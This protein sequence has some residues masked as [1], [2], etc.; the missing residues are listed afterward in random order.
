MIKVFNVQYLRN[1]SPYRVL[2][3]AAW[4][5][6]EAVRLCATGI[7]RPIDEDPELLAAIKVYRAPRV[8]TPWEY[9]LCQP[10]FF[11]FNR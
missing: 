9:Y 10:N 8:N 3:V 7:C 5:L 2:E 1:A 6:D 11:K 4:P